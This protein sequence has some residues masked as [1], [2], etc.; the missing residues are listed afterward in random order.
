M[1]LYTN[2]RRELR[3]KYESTLGDL[4]HLFSRKRAHGSAFPSIELE[5]VGV[6]DGFGSFEEWKYNNGLDIKYVVTATLEKREEV[7][8]ARLTLF[9]SSNVESLELPSLPPPSPPLGVTVFPDEVPAEPTVLKVPTALEDPKEDPAPTPVVVHRP[10][11]KPSTPDAPQP[12]A[13][14]PTVPT[15]QPVAGPSRINRSPTPP[16][17]ASMN[18]IQPRSRRV[19]SPSLPPVFP[20]WVSAANYTVAENAPA[21]P[22]HILMPLE[23][24]F[25]ANLPQLPP[26]DAHR[27]RRKDSKGDKGPANLYK[28][29][30]T[31][32]INPVSSSLSKSS[33]CVLTSD[34]RVAMAELRHIRAMERIEEKKENGRWSLR[35]PKKLKTMPVRKAHWDYLL[36]EMVSSDLSTRL[37]R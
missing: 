23:S 19:F 29:Q 4:Y 36:D 17:T 30:A 31:Y 27:R 34:W 16:M 2:V 6:D 32:E 28:L 24:D 13:Y 11:S 33:K 14:S 21:T 37:N 8:G 7:R 18:D 1:R 25:A 3:D 9:R 5:D 35:Q 10:A 22:P 12:P 15:F 20:E 26:V